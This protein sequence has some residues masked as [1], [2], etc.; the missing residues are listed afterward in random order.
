MGPRLRKSRDNLQS[1]ALQTLR[2]LPFGSLKPDGRKLFVN[3][4]DDATSSLN[5]VVDS[6]LCSIRA[7]LQLLPPAKAQWHLKIALARLTSLD[8]PSGYLA[9]IC[10]R[11]GTQ[12]GLLPER[13]LKR[14]ELHGE[15]DRAKKKHLATISAWRSNSS[16]LLA[17]RLSSRRNSRE[18]QSCQ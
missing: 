8:R 2:A 1:S 16:G 11:A 15:T 7:R 13:V 3:I 12:N 18:F 5:A 10:R 14:L 6:Q 17:W 4:L 9:G